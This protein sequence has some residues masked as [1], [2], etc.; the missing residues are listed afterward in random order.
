MTLKNK[1]LILTKSSI[2][3]IAGMIPPEPQGYQSI[4]GPIVPQ[5]G[6]TNS[7]SGGV[8]DNM[9]LRLI[10]TVGVRVFRVDGDRCPCEA[11]DSFRLS[12]VLRWTILCSMLFVPR[13]TVYR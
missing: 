2:C 5:L 11:A 4:F 12:F 6:E 9:V 13:E 8:C 10:V 1:P 7:T 3:F